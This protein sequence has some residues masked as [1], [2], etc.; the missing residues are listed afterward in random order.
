MVSS[1]LK[2]SVDSATPTKSVM[3]RMG[4][5]VTPDA[6]VVCPD[7]SKVTMMAELDLL[8]EVYCTCISGK[9][10][11]G[12]ARVLH[13]NFRRVWSKHIICTAL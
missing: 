1:P 5:K 10:P 3:P 11:H 2:L 6:L 9:R 7:P 4:S 12:G 8:A 13:S